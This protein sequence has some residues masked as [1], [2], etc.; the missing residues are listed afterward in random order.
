MRPFLVLLLILSVITACEFKNEEQLEK[1]SC[2][3]V[4]INY[5]SVKPIFDQ[6]C[7]VCHNEQVN[8]FGIKL[9]TYV[10][11]K[12]AAQTGLLVKA[13]NHLPGVVPMPFQRPKLED[14]DVRKITL[15]IE[16]GI[17]Q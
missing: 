10:N 15:W 7:L 8:Y 5:N 13:V 3:T 14:C 1:Y 9:D 6:N 4:N 11:A 12:N 16:S 2:D 17:P